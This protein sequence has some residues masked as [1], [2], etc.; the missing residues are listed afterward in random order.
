L[1]RVCTCIS[2]GLLMLIAVSLLT[3]PFTQ[4]V[5]T[6]DRFLHGGQDFESGV[7]L[8]LVSFCLLLV[9]SQL[10]KRAVSLVLAAFSLSSR[11]SEDPAVQGRGA[12]CRRAGGDLS[13]PARN[14]R[15]PLT[16]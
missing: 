9:L 13:P 3:S 12:I 11:T 6:W 5:W 8:I 16:I 15:L 7:L 2:F 1:A 14:Y 4:G 10:F